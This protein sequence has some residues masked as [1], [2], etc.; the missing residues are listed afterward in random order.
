EE[1]HGAGL[2][3]Y[4]TLDLDLQAVANKAVL[5]GAATYERREGWKGRL[6]NI[7][8]AGQDVESYKHPDWVQPVVKDAYVHG[9]VT[10]VEPK[11]VT[12][13]LGTEVAVLTPEDW[14]WTQNTDADSFLRNGDVVYLRI[15]GA[16][17]GGTWKASL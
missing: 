8:L 10:A 9:L 6:P 1:V 11:R 2:R 17:A 7:V 16:G 13:K 12:V 3:V 14:K 15:E 4:T 5:D